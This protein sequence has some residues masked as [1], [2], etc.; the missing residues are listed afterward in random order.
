[1]GSSADVRPA[2]P[3]GVEDGTEA[4][5]LRLLIDSVKDYA[6]FRLDPEGRVASWNS[7]AERIKGYTAADILGKH[8]STF[9]TAEDI[10]AGKCER[11]LEGA[12]RDGR[13]EDEGWRVRKDGSRFWANVV[14]S[15]MRDADG[16]LRGFGKV[17]RDL[18]TRV[19]A[20]E[21]RV[22][23][24]RAEE[25]E[26][27][28]EQFLAVMG[29]EL[30][31][32]LAP[33]LTAVHLIKL[34]GGGAENERE[35]T[36]LERQLVHM[37][38]LIDELLDVSRML[39]DEVHLAT[40]AMEVGAVL[41]DAVVAIQHLVDHKKQVLRVEVP[42]EPLAVDVD[43][44]RIAQVFVNILGNAS[45]YTGIGGGI[46]VR[47]HGE[48]EHVRVEIEDDGVGIPAAAL[49]RIFDLF[50]QGAH[51]KD[52]HLGGFGIGLAV[53]RQLV[54]AHGGTLTAESEGLG[55]GSRFVVRLPRADASRVRDAPS[56]LPQLH[57]AAQSRRVL[58]VD[59][60]QDSVEMLEVLLTRLG[61]EVRTA[62][63][64]ASALAL[65]P[66]FAPQIAFLDIGLPGM[67]GF[68]LARSLR[69]V[70]GCATIPLIAVSGYA[71]ES[72]RREALS[73]GFDDYFAKPIDLARLGELV[74]LARGT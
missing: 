30:R 17:T 7:G 19:R 43:P 12:A 34:R 1:M 42:S 67:N 61:H 4:E 56:V 70:P 36:V 46:R 68:E 26:R 74:L 64:G 32:P 16:R 69:K 49:P 63:D 3:S 10:T 27:Q 35:L 54:T 50:E 31:N 5:L 21:E 39:R 38:R 47:A 29:H 41:A 33:M 11:E 66:E 37:L 6:I 24:A 25:R 52:H 2:A 22:Q 65:A 71:R 44:D 60:N 15:A 48:A 8:F 72:D 28:R 51:T 40:R 45:R 58:I 9:Y 20:E 62:L 73:A 53:A 57:R 59:D 14:I 23:R 13:F 55:R 18:T